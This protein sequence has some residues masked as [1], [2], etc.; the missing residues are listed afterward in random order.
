MTETVTSYAELPALLTIF[1]KGEF[2]EVFVISEPLQCSYRYASDE[3][4]AHIGKQPEHEIGPKDTYFPLRRYA[5][6][7]AGCVVPHRLFAL[8]DHRTCILVALSPYVGASGGG[9]GHLCCLSTINPIW[10]LMLVYVL[11]SMY[12]HKAQTVL[13]RGYGMYLE[14]YFWFVFAE[15]STREAQERLR[16]FDENVGLHSRMYP[17]QLLM[18]QKKR[19]GSPHE[20]AQ[21]ER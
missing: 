3:D 4:V 10:L 15:R 2:F 14:H 19:C 11:L 9:A 1:R 16:R 8:C 5:I 17:N 18:R 13:M 7:A 21:I 20:A 12:F 6:C